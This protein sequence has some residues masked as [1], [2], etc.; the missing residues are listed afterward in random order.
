M[1][2]QKEE[3]R[4][5]KKAVTVSHEQLGQYLVIALGSNGI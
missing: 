5:D 2:T 1:V 4:K 3:N